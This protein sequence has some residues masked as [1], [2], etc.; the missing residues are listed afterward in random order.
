[1]ATLLPNRL[2]CHG[3]RNELASSRVTHLQAFPI[4]QLRVSRAVL[5]FFV[6][7]FFCRGVSL[8]SY[9]SS[10]SLKIGGIKDL[11]SPKRHTCFRQLTDQDI[12][13]S[14]LCQCDSLPDMAFALKTY[15]QPR[16]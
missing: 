4:L 2:R 5:L 8:S 6:L 10:S 16:L 11:D 9:F 13:P 7:Y 14:S 12:T 1:M 15:M 3:N